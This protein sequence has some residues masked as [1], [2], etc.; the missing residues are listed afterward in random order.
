MKKLSGDDQKRL[1]D[2][3]LYNVDSIKSK[4]NVGCSS[5][6]CTSSA[7]SEEGFKVCMTDYT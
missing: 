7:K 4:E 5:G 3:V 6:L 2:T 1:T